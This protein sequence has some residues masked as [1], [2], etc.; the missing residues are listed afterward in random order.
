MKKDFSLRAEIA[1]LYLTLIDLSIEDFTSK[2]STNLVKTFLVNTDC[3]EPLLQRVFW[4]NQLLIKFL[5]AIESKPDNFELPK[6]YKKIQSILETGG[7]GIG[8]TFFENLNDFLKKCPLLNFSA[9]SGSKKFTGSLNDTLKQVEGFLKAYMSCLETDICKFYMGRLVDLY[10]DLSYHI[11]VECV[12][13]TR[14]LISEQKLYNDKDLTEPIKKNIES[15]MDKFV[16]LLMLYPLDLYLERNSPDHMSELAV[17]I[18]NYKFIPKAYA[19]FLKRLILDSPTEIL[20]GNKDLI[21]KAL[22]KFAGSVAKFADDKKKFESYLILIDNLAKERIVSRSEETSSLTDIIKQLFSASSQ[23]LK[24]FSTQVFDSEK[25]EKAFVAES[26]TNFSKYF[27]NLLNS[28]SDLNKEI[29]DTLVPEVVSRLVATLVDCLDDQ[30]D[31]FEDEKKRL[32]ILH[33]LFSVFYTVQTWKAKEGKL[34]FKEIDGVFSKLLIHIK[35]VQSVDDSLF[36]TKQANIATIVSALTPNLKPELLLRTLKSGKVDIKADSVTWAESNVSFKLSTFEHF[37][38]SAT[39][40]EVCQQVLQTF[41]AS[42]QLSAMIFYDFARRFSRFVQEPT[43]LHILTKV[44]SRTNNKD[45]FVGYKLASIESRLGHLEGRLPFVYLLFGYIHEARTFP[46]DATICDLEKFMDRLPPQVKNQIVRSAVDLLIKPHEGFKDQ[47][48]ANL[49]GTPGDYVVLLDFFLNKLVT[50]DDL[51]EDTAQALVDAVTGPSNFGPQVLSEIYPWLVLKAVLKNL[52]GKKL[53]KATFVAILH[54]RNSWMTA[55]CLLAS[56]SC[57]QIVMTYQLRAFLNDLCS[58]HLLPGLMSL[59]ESDLP[60]FLGFVHE[61]IALATAQDMQFVYALKRVLPQVTGDESIDDDVKQQVFAQVCNSLQK[62]AEAAQADR[63]SDLV[64]ITA[65]VMLYFNRGLL[66]LAFVHD[67]KMQARAKVFQALGVAVTPLEGELN[68]KEVEVQNYDHVNPGEFVFNLALYLSLCRGS[69]GNSVYEFKNVCFDMIEDKRFSVVKREVLLTLLIRM[70]NV[71]IED[72]DLEKFADRI[73]QIEATYSEG[74]S[75]SSFGAQKNLLL[76]SMLE[77]IRKVLGVLEMFS[78]EFEQNIHSKIMDLAVSRVQALKKVHFES[79]PLLQNQSTSAEY[80]C[81]FDELLVEFAETLSRFSLS[82]K[83]NIGENELYFLLNSEV[84]VVQKSAFV[85]LLD[86]YENKIVPSRDFEEVDQTEDSKIS[87]QSPVIPELLRILQ[88]RAT[89]TEEGQ[90]QK[91]TKKKQVQESSEILEIKENS[92]GKDLEIFSYVLSWVQFMQ[93]LKSARME[94]SAEQ[95]YYE[96]M[97]TSNPQLYFGFLNHLFKWLVSLRIPGKE[98]EKI[99]DKSPMAEI[100][101]Q[102][103]D[104]ISRDTMIDLVLHAFYKFSSGFPKFLRNWMGI[105]T[106]DT[107]DSQSKWFDRRLAG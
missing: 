88:S 36:L 35:E 57:L 69:K 49:S 82:Q 103:T 102:W 52:Q 43:I 67:F 32:E 38:P 91:H 42:K 18:N 19:R 84:P 71:A 24:D 6:V 1:H 74:I 63:L 99:I 55:H 51:E 76:V 93:R 16:D 7:M 101:L 4:E 65:S 72:G 41:M 28:D 68:A 9:F 25:V 23:F 105:L 61:S 22:N 53:V 40:K 5:P 87:I 107:Q 37:L 56:P 81:G 80:G 33:H 104:F 20:I 46:T 30:F 2:Q 92:E 12:L 66:K 26:F 3:K 15:F 13:K 100:P 94:E 85:V 14:T 89:S 54:D 34:D 48:K 86:Y 62:A 21:E 59:A 39:F 98:L 10:F 50:E 70:L 47:N 73:P 95:K 77:F 31:L 27:S 44:L 11:L 64:E 106:R 78:K 79:N 60:A 8:V 29:R 17:G 75:L 58:A 45:E 90:M 97:L 83:V 96:N